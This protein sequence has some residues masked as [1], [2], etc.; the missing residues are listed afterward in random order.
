MK[1]LIFQVPTCQAAA[2]MLI[3]QVALPSA[4]QGLERRKQGFE[5]RKQGLY[6][7]GWPSGFIRL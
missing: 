4:K 6:G 3:L 2:F 1:K 7:S 5:Q